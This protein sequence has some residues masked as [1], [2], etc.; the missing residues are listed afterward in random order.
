MELARP[1]VEPGIRTDVEPSLC[2]EGMQSRDTWTGLRG[3]PVQ[4]NMKF[5]KSKCKV[6]NMG[7][8]PKQK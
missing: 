1:Q 2:K 8:N 3:E 4:N 5:N 7:Q 6:L